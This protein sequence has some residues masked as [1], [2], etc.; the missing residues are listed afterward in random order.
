M[1]DIR[2][3]P[4]ESRSNASTFRAAR[5][6]QYERLVWW[7]WRIFAVGAGLFLSL[8]VIFSFFTPSF[9][10]LEDPSFNVASDVLAMDGVT[11]LGR[12]YI[13]NRAP[14]TF[15]QL[16]PWVPK[17]LISTEDARFREHSGVDAEALARV[18]VKTGLLRQK[19]QGGGSTITQQLA[20]LLYSNR[21]NS[22]GVFKILYY[23][24]SEW[25]TAVKLERAYT[26]EEIAA[27]YLNQVNFVNGAYG[28]RAASEIYFGKSPDSLRAEEAAT[29]VGM[30]QNPSLFNPVRRPDRCKERRNQV[31]GKM[32]KNGALTESQYKTLCAKPLDMSKFKTKSHLDG[33]APYFRTEAAKDIQSILSKNNIK[34]SDGTSY[35][36]YR[37]GLKVYTTIDPNIQ[38]YAEEALRE[39]MSNL[40]NKFFATWKGRDPWTYKDA[41]TTDQDIKERRSQL[42]RDIRTTD[43]YELLRSRFLDASIEEL[44][45]NLNG[46]ELKDSDID[47]MIQAEKTPTIFETMLKNKSLSSE[48]ISMY[49]SVISSDQWTALKP[50]WVK[51]Q[52]AVTQEFNKLTKMRVFAYST[53]GEKDTTM[54]PLDSIKYHQ[55]FLQL[56]S[57]AVEPTTG[58]VK[59]WVGGI[60]FKYFK[61][62]HV[63]S[64]RQVGS[65]I[66]PFVYSAAVKDLS[67]SPCMTIHDV[68]TTINAGESSFG[69]ASAWTPRNSGGY[70]GN[71]MTL[72]EALKESKN[73]ASVY[74]LKQ[75][76]TTEP[77]RNVMHNMGI[78]STSKYSN[79]IYRVP[80][81]PSMCLGTPEL[82][83][84]EMTGAYATFANQG[85][86]IKPIYITKIVTRQGQVL[87][88]AIPEEHP[89]LPENANYVMVKMLKYVAAAA[90]NLMKLKSD[91]GGKTGTTNDFVD[92]WFMGVTPQLVVGTWVG[93]ENKWVRFLSIANGQG[94]VMARPFFE[95]LLTKIEA[96]GA[97]CHY[98]PAKRFE[99]VDEAA[100]GIT[101]DCS[102]YGGEGGGGIIAPESNSGNSG[103]FDEG[104][105]PPSAPSGGP[106]APPAPKPNVPAPVGGKPATV[107]APSIGKPLPSAPKPA[108]SKPSSPKAT[109]PNDDD[110]GG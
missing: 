61:Y 54:T 81:S 1:S 44:K 10:Q 100:L 39:H 99:V 105:P 97:A 19:M 41:E 55:M 88:Q 85:K 46:Y 15:E 25:I 68:P 67:I 40:Q 86:Y 75:F 59:A 38:K 42:I 31:F 102:K 96:N 33:M 8:I 21:E 45:K 107:P 92:G 58:F 3:T 76:G 103:E 43:R 32:L 11:V 48:K 82:S 30:L 73:T 9:K 98:D 18:F 28:I 49:R 80:R 79:G 51:L 22:P 90:P 72:W 24:M 101:I 14:V 77:V 17:A 4:N 106:S 23:K 35:D 93:G 84:F 57:I 13:E 64:N 47:A 60:N 36:I 71:Y 83:V 27:M 56:G 87:Y 91:I 20:K 108:T 29:I 63:R 16:S 70:S 2:P 66:K 34:K 110:F 5:A 52:T 26:K 95:K 78:D 89:A 53:S 6:T 109:K 74:L 50:A 69:L 12:Y 62:D 94:S 37:D 104:T 65:T 7:M